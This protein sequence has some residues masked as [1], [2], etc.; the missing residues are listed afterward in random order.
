LT[1]THKTFLALLA[2]ICIAVFFLC[3]CGAVAEEYGQPISTTTT[4]V[5]TGLGG[6]GT[7]SAC[8]G[9]STAVTTGSVPS[10]FATNTNYCFASGTYA[11]FNKTIASGDGWY[12]QGAAILNG[13]G[14]QQD[15]ISGSGNNITIDGFTIT[16]YTYNCSSAQY[17][18]QVLNAGSI[19]LSSGTNIDINNNT[20]SADY[21]GGYQ[22]TNPIFLGGNDPPG[23]Y[24]Q[25]AT[26][27][28]VQNSEIEHN[29]FNG[30]GLGGPVVQDA[31]NVTVGYNEVE[32]SDEENM[33]TEAIIGAIG[34]F[35]LTADITVTGNYLTDNPENGIWFDVY[36]TDEIVTNNVIEDSSTQEA[37]QDGVMIEI[38]GN[39]VITGNLIQNVGYS[40]SNTGNHGAAVRISSSGSCAPSL[41]GAPVYSQCGQYNTDNAMPGPPSITISG[42]TFTNDLEDVALYDGHEQNS[43]TPDEVNNVNV[44]GNTFNATTE[45]GYVVNP[46]VTYTGPTE[47]DVDVT[48]ITTEQSVS[49]SNNTYN[50]QSANQHVFSGTTW[51]NWK[52]EG[53]DTSGSTCEIV[54]V[55]AC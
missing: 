45:A 49:F 35:A 26:Y 52:G 39:A 25:V 20:F 48:A 2:L 42:N 50:I 21:Q 19:W 44:T 28:T 10:S 54:G 8:P 41:A 27:K 18:C 17:E 1:R 34:K 43:T 31:T 37:A 13:E 30:M 12:G 15:G 4:T 29:L 46:E 22:G 3:S 51:S 32:N 24:D 53:F 38:S 40:D 47:S 6:L 7:A 5:P 55:G 14:A 16:D 11:N 33:D 36:D 23:Q 9:G